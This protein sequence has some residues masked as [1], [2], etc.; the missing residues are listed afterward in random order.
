MRRV[1]WRGLPSF[2]ELT[3][4][5]AISTLYACCSSTIWAIRVA[6]A[7]PFSDDEALLEYADLILAELSEGDLDEALS[8]H[9]RIGDRADNPSS[10][11]EQSGVTGADAAVL[12]ELKELNAAY[13]DRF[14]HVYLVF[15]NG[16]PAAELLAILKERIRNDPATERRVM[17]AELAKINRSR[18]IRMLTPAGGLNEE[19]AAS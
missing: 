13:E 12:A 18:L 11:R 17:R 7:R 14:G 19:G 16:R 9:P 1:D 10:A 8:G 6:A 15:A 5:Q 2:N 4:R 3:E